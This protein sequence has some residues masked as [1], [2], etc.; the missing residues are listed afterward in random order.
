[1]KRLTCTAIG[2]MAGVS[3]AL[4]LRSRVRR[5]VDRYTP[6]RMR[7]AM[8]KGAK[9]AKR[10]A[11]KAV[12]GASRRVIGEVRLIADDI[13]DAVVDGRDT[14]RRTEDDLNSLP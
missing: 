2:Y 4:W 11:R 1:M 5:T 7:E 13:R 10:Q 12:K 6:A 9:A 14:M 8:A 3:T